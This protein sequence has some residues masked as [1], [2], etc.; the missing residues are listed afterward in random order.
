MGKL[1]TGKTA[2]RVLAAVLIVAAV[3]AGGYF[4]THREACLQEANYLGG[5]WAMLGDEVL[6]RRIAIAK[7][8]ATAESVEALLEHE[9]PAMRNPKSAHEELR[10]VALPDL[11]SVYAY[12][13][14]YV[15]AHEIFAAAN[16]LSPVETTADIGA[17][18]NVMGMSDEEL[19][20]MRPAMNQAIDYMSALLSVKNASEVVVDCSASNIFARLTGGNPYVV[21]VHVRAEIV[22]AA[23]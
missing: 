16:K 19:V 3:A 12:V 20:K 9:E 22:P 6:T 2:A 23:K 17:S 21:K 11:E 5:Q 18:G 13:S 4:Y 8:F 15:D 1:I 10:D 7:Q 14:D